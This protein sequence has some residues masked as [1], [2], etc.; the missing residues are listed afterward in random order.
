[1]CAMQAEPVALEEYSQPHPLSG[2]A[3]M[4]PGRIYAGKHGTV[5]LFVD[6]TDNTLVVYSDM[7]PHP[8]DWKMAEQV[9]DVCTGSEGLRCWE[10]YEEGVDVFVMELGSD[11]P[12]VRVLNALAV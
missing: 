1:M 3:Q 10:E 4:L 12:M 6:Y 5:A 8:D 11:S 2:Q 9:I 7:E